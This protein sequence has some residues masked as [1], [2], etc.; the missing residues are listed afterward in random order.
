MMN[1]NG[2]GYEDISDDA[3]RIISEEVYNKWLKIE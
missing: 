3:R 2:K 1:E